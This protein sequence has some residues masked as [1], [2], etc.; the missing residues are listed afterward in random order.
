MAAVGASVAQYL[1]KL[2][3]NAEAQKQLTD[4]IQAIADGYI[5]GKANM[6]RAIEIIGSIVK[7]NDGFMAVYEPLRKKVFEDGD[8]N[9]TKMEI[10]QLAAVANEY[11][12]TAKAK[13]KE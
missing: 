5:E 12:K 3:N 10:M 6:L 13:I 11:S 9:L 7:C 8:T 2:D 4:N 1:Q